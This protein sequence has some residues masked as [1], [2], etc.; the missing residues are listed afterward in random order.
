M[1]LNPVNGMFLVV[2]KRNAR[3]PS[4]KDRVLNMVCIQELQELIP[5]LK[6]SQSDEFTLQSGFL[7]K[8]RKTFDKYYRVNSPTDTLNALIEEALK[9]IE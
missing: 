9:Y 3:D 1:D 7:E 8:L 4:I 2:E 5:V 6:R